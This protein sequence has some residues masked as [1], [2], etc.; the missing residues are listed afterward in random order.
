VI[1]F[2][3]CAT[4]GRSGSHYL[5]ELLK[6]VEGCRA[7]HEPEPV[8]NGYPMREYL[9]GNAAPLRALMPGKLAVMESSRGTSE[10][11][12]ETNHCFIKGFGWLLPEYLEADSIGVIGLHRDPECVRRSL[13]RVLCSPF[14][15]SGD[16][17]I[18]TPAAF[19]RQIELPAGFRFPLLRFH[20]YRWL[21]RTIARPG[22]V[23]RFSGGRS[24][25]LPFIHRYEQALLNWYIAETEARWR[26][27]QKQ[28][29]AIRAVDVVL[30]DLNTVEGV[31]ALLDAFELQPKRTLAD[32]VGKRTNP[33]TRRRRTGF[34][35]D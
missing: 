18:I 22:I 5:C 1:R 3:F 23:R 2:I 14:L 15:P 29:P 27:Y 7:E 24:E 13:S 12:A 8:M 35:Q 21:S 31:R 19:P 11:Y 26:L 17:W 32:V 25:A 4:T 28:Y 30:D 34:A 16:Q 33:K 9:R 6:Q 10:V 20:L